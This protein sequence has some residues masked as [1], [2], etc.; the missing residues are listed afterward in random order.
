LK[1]TGA[2]FDESIRS[3]QN[4]VGD[5]VDSQI[6][7][8]HIPLDRYGFIG[9][10]RQ[11]LTPD[12]VA[13]GDTVTVSDS[14]YLREMDIY[15]LSRGYGSNFQVLRTADSHFGLIDSFENSF[16]RLQGTWIQ[17]LIQPQ[18]L[19]L[20]SLPELL[21]SGRQQLA[22][23]LAYSDFD[24]QAINY[25]RADGVDG[26]R[27]DL[28][29]RLILP[30]RWGDYL[31]G[32]FN[33]GARETFY[34]VSG[35]NI[36]VIPAGT[37]GHTNNNGLFLDGLTPGG[38]HSRE[39]VYG[40][41]RVSSILEK[42]Y[43][44][45]WGSLEGLKH[46]IEPVVDYNYVPQVQQGQLPLFDAVDR[47]EPRSLLTYGFVS[48]VFAKFGGG[49]AESTPAEVE[50]D[51][52]EEL[53]ELRPVETYSQ[54]SSVRELVRLSLMQSF[55]SLHAVTPSGSRLSDAEAI[56]TLLPTNIASFGSTIDYNPHDQKMDA[57]TIFMAVRPPWERI[58]PATTT[59][60][61]RAMT[62]GPFV[63]M[64]YNFIGGSQG[65]HSFSA[66]AY[67]EFF[68][69]IGLYYQPSYDIADGRMLSTEYGLRLKSPCNCWNFDLG[70]VDSFNPSETQVQVML[71]LGGV[72]SIGHNPF[73][74]NPFQSHAG[75]G[76]IQPY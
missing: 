31:Y 19:A 33:F 1:L 6:A 28:N 71:T 64:D 2:F 9:L 62:G 50:N 76:V 63:Q 67:W 25:W 16:L 52:E 20:Q 17:D 66:R 57:A 38:F 21:F 41:A 22:G 47:I 3:E 70:I 4:R 10:A 73:G 56:V 59:R 11:H 39:M 43:H 51:T 40:E 34:D 46:T 24:L 26:Q 61:G 48:R 69:R 7:D 42:I 23:G 75:A 55:D 74:R 15:T 49:P 53:A 72:G 60:T 14:L 54:G 18:N 44:V 27:V 36:G 35:H 30:W 45:H 29:P 12:L 32:L 13:Y 68:D 5:I 37:P 58:A 65:L 8:P